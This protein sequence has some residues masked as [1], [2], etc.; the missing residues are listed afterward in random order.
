M[1]Q[2][3][4][5]HGEDDNERGGAGVR[6]MA[7]D[8][9]RA[10]IVSGDLLPG[11][12][13]P[14]RELCALTGAARTTV[15]EAVRQLESEG[16]ITSIPYRGPVIA[17]L[18]DREARDIYEL[19]AMLEGQAG[20]LFVQRAS[21]EFVAE[22]RRTVEDIGRA[23]AARDMVG[24]ITSSDEFYKVLTEGAANKA[25]SQVLLT[26]HNRLALF[27]FSSTRWPGRAERSM[28]E[29]RDIADAVQ[30]R[31]AAA[32]EA[33]CIHHIEAAAEL[34]L[35][36]LAERAR[37]AAAASRSRSSNHGARS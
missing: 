35:M 21:G 18:T 13:V 9:I 34:A 6:E 31:D 10:A 25:L 23:H 4:A 33:A 29:L 12:R 5:F 37:G 14:E 28:A 26:I 22:L 20:R 36:V 30:A 3:Q 19:R 7:A 2:Q 24:V 17:E 1:V 8:R 32:A 11:Q 15:R 16:L 27:R